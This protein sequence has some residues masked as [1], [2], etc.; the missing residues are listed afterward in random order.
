MSVEFKNTGN[1]PVCET[2]I[3]DFETINTKIKYKSDLEVFLRESKLE[4][5]YPPGIDTI[6]VSTIH[7]A[8]GREFDNLFLMLENYVL[9]DD[10]DKRLVYVAITRAKQNLTIHLNTNIFDN[11][12]TSNIVRIEDDEQH[13]P[14]AWLAMHLTHEDVWLDFFYKVQETVATLKAG[15]DLIV[16]GNECST[17]LRRP[18]L[19]FSA[20]FSGKLA[21]IDAK[22]YKLKSVKVN[23][24]IYWRKE[25]TEKEIIIVLPKLYFER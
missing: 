8:K 16:T 22:G 24:L 10:E 9:K 18:V 7:K 15:D 17:L 20:S 4:D 5:F 1:W 25:N 6:F 12:G 2:L 13:A 21:A 14:P 23:F 19:E 3:R 11:I